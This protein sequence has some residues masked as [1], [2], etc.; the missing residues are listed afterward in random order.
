MKRFTKIL[1][2]TGL[3][4]LFIVVGLVATVF[5]RQNLKF[6]A[7]Y[8]RIVASQDTAVIARGRHLV[9]SMAHC[10]YCHNRGNADS[11]IALGQEVPLDGGVM[12]DL[13]IGKVYSKNITSDKET[14]IGKYSDEEIARALRFG[15]HPDGAAVFDFMPFHD[16]SDEDLT[17]IISYIRMQKPVH[18]QVPKN[19]LN[20]MGKA[21]NAFLVKPVGPVAEPPATVPADSTAA[22][23]SYIA[24]SI[25]ECN[26]CHTQ[27]DM[28]GRFVGEPFAGGNEIEGFITPNL[29]TDSTGTLFGW[30]K[31]TFINRFRAGKLKTGTPMPWNAFKHM[32]DQELTAVYNFL[33]TT[34]PVKT[35]W[36]EKASK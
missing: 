4:I 26:G 23:G 21:V 11:L 8:P 28:A 27:R 2:W 16:L 13:P 3:V 30:T 15:V 14:G 1:K 6:T 36:P 22:Y 29:T 25:A 34:K 35:A 19:E 24:M 5:A 32:T 10:V 17:A 18:N 9:Y 31:E 20:F 33:K 7:P 12:F